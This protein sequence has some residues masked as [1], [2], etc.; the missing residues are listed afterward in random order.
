MPEP[1]QITRALLVALLAEIGEDDPYGR[2][3]VETAIK[4][5]D[6]LA[7]IPAEAS[8]RGCSRIAALLEELEWTEVPK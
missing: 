6:A 3:I 5:G 2:A 1:V 4:M 7:A 8:F